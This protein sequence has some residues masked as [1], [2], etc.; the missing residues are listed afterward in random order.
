M[1]HY[2]MSMYQPD[3][4]PPPPEVLDPIMEQLGALEQEMKDSGVWVFS[5]G[6]HPPSTA[7]VLR[8]KDD[9]VLVV[10]GPFAEVKEMLGGFTIFMAEDLDAALA[11]GRRYA[12]IVGLPIEIR[13]FA[14]TDG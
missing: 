4:P 6:L 7:T 10:D 8:A 12:G 1:K 11:W 13:P 14:F 3:A 5:G 2:L 9:E